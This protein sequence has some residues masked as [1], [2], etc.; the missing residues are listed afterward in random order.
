M[1]KIKPIVFALQGEATQLEVN[2]M[3]HTTDAVTCGTYNRLL[4]EEGK[5]VMKW[6]YYLTEEEFEAWG[7]DNSVV[8]GFVATD[9][10]IEII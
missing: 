7:A 6:N 9:K 8:D 2:I 10:G 1:T 4:T 5:E 3:Q